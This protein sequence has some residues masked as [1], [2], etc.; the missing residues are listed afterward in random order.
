MIGKRFPWHAMGVNRKSVYPN[1][2]NTQITCLNR[3]ISTP[4]P[5]IQKTKT[6]TK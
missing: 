3:H 5:D 1:T 4:K 2:E 6:G